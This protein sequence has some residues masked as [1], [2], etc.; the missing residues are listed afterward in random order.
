MAGKCSSTPGERALR[1][2]PLIGFIPALIL[3]I[4][5]GV[6]ARAILC[7]ILFVPLVHTLFSS[8]AY[9]YLARQNRKN[10]GLDGAPNGLRLVL[11]NLCTFWLWPI[12][13]LAHALTYLGLLIGIWVTMTRNNHHYS[14]YYYQ[15]DAPDAMLVAYAT[16]V[17]LFNM[18]SHFYLAVVGIFIWLRRLSTPS[19]CANCGHAP[20]QT[21]RVGPVMGAQKVRDGATYSL[22][23]ERSY[24]YDDDAVRASLESGPSEPRP[25][26][27]TAAN[28]V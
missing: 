26:E 7:F 14:Y 9:L 3:L 11:H 16:V 24:E 1:I 13:D 19:A 12:S 10:H 22:L 20:G 28:K 21:R 15:S 8:L 17:P 25:T 18:T 27:E 5:S 4:V 23:G 6:I 2:F